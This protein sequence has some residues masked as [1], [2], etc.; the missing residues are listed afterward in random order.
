MNAKQKNLVSL[1]VG[2]LVAGGLGLYAWLGVMKPAEQEEQRKE[3]DSALFPVGAPEAPVV[4]SLTVEARR[5]KTVMELK[6]GVWRVTSPVSAR[7][8]RRLVEGLVQQ[9]V[10]AK[11]KA[12]VEENPTDADLERYGLKPPKASVSARALSG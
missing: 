3:A 8:D 10:S 5:S 11:F 9:L 12:T 7:A 1:L 4:T 2:A 6:D